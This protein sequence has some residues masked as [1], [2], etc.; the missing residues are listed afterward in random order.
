MFESLFISVGTALTTRF[1]LGFFIPKV[2]DFFKGLFGKPATT[3]PETIQAELCETDQEKIAQSQ[4]LF[5]EHFG[6]DVCQTI[7][8]MSNMERVD[9]ANRFANDL[10]KLYDVDV[11]IDI[12]ISNVEE[13]GYYNHLE[14]KAVFNILE[15][16]VSND[17]PNFESH[18]RNFFD[19]IVHELRHAVQNKAVEEPGFWDIDEARRKAWEENLKPGNYIDPQVD[20]RGYMMQPTENDATTFAANVL[21][22]VFTK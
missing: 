20:I 21:E 22:G 8:N 17:N 7:R 6:E 19:T 10:A 3:V 5:H 16:L 15:L 1:I 13:C 12:N 9:A 14:N 11:N 2:S 18:I 4:A